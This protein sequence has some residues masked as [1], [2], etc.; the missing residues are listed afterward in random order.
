M[1]K[2][3][4][5]AF[6]REACPESGGD[7]TFTWMGAPLELFGVGIPGADFAPIRAI[8]YVMAT[9]YLYRGIEK[10]GN[11]IWMNRT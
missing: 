8:H 10:P 11:V 6:D 1:Y 7:L 5:Y 3:S 2:F 9:S 4:Q